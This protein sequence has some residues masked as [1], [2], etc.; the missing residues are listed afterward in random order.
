MHQPDHPLTSFPPPPVPPQP[1]SGGRGWG[2]NS[3]VRELDFELM[4]IYLI[5]TTLNQNRLL[6][7]KRLFNLEET[8]ITL[9]GRVGVCEKIRSVKKSKEAKCPS[10]RAV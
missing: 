2:K 6:N 7:H 10:L 5:E 3:L 4:S 8:E 9:I 1:P